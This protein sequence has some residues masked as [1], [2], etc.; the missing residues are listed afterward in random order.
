MTAR[1][2]RKAKKMNTACIIAGLFFFL[3]PNI[4]V[5]DPLPDFIGAILLLIGTYR[6]SKIDERCS[7]AY[8]FIKITLGVSFARALSCLLYFV[9]DESEST[10]YLVLSF[11]FGIAEAALFVYA[12]FKLADG[13]SYRAMHANAAELYEVSG[14]KTATAFFFIFK[15]ALSILPQ[16]IFLASDYGYIES[17]EI[18]RDFLYLVL[19]AINVIAVLAVGIFWFCRVRR[20]IKKAPKNEAFV[21]YVN[22]T[23]QSEYALDTARVAHTKVKS[24]A[25]FF[26]AAFIFALPA[27]FSG[28]DFLPDFLAAASFFGAFAILRA[29]YPKLCRKAMIPT[30][31]Y[32]VISAIEWCA[33]TI[34]ASHNADLLDST[35]SYSEMLYGA[36]LHEPKQYD[37][38]MLITLLHALCALSL[39][40]VLVFAFLIL[41]E[42]IKD[43]TGVAP[44]VHTERTEEKNRRMHK[45]LTSFCL[46]CAIAIFVFAAFDVAAFALTVEVPTLW[47]YG[48]F[49]A[50]AAT[51]C[52]IVMTERV[53]SGIENKYFYL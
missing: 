36:F 26:S 5:F 6:L 7:E 30:A 16:F 40:S 32:F 31:I 2:E 14:E 15:A 38:F 18:D 3:N 28:I 8:K 46:V 43:H 41:R 37:N 23:Y 34:F 33:S 39:A 12:F 47:A 42:V 53:K 51:V 45:K 27:R 25:V 49:G 29:L 21:A 11:C 4:S 22:E 24:A 48:F 44:E 20:Y 10:W 13:I 9:I 52:A 1:S 50:L 17:F 19:N 35:V